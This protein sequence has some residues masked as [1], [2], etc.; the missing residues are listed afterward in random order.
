[1]AQAMYSSPHWPHFQDKETEA[2]EALK[3]GGETESRS[4]KLFM[5]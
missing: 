1:M 5:A 4:W 3:T 2:L